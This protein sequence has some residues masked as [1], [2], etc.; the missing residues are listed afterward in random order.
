MWD[1]AVTHNFLFIFLFHSGLNPQKRSR[2]KPAL[3]RVPFLDGVNGDLEYSSSG[4]K[5]TVWKC[6]WYAVIISAT[7][8]LSLI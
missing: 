2:G 6:L 5:I 3:A 4:E 1:W 8:A 7:R